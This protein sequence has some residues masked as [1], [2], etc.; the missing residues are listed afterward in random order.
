MKT[1][2]NFFFSKKTLALSILSFLAF[3]GHLA[4][5]KSDFYINE[6][7]KKASIREQREHLLSRHEFLAFNLDA[8]LDQYEREQKIDILRI[9][10]IIPPPPSP[11]SF[12][13]LF[14]LKTNPFFCSYFLI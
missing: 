5:Q 1:F 7:F 10:V 11:S 3:K 9:E 13:S 12:S 6:V 2:K 14:S 4:K 8:N